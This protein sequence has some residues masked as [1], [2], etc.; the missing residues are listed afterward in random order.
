[1]SPADRGN[2]MLVAGQPRTHANIAAQL[3]KPRVVG[4]GPL[5]G[6]CIAQCGKDAERLR[7]RSHTRLRLMRLIVGF[8]VQ[9]LEPGGFGSDENVVSNFPSWVFVQG[10]SMQ[11]DHFPVIGLRRD[12]RAALGAKPH[13]IARRIFVL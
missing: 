4:E 9:D 7:G 10:A 3:P 13:L 6:S 12:R 11:E 8:G 5:C 2:K 1:M